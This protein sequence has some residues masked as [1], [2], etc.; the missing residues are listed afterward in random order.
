[1]EDNSQYMMWNW[2]VIIAPSKDQH[3]RQGISTIE[4]DSTEWSCRVLIK[5]CGRI[6]FMKFSSIP[7]Q[8]HCCCGLINIQLLEDSHN[9]SMVEEWSTN[10]YWN[11]HPISDQRSWKNPQEID[12]SESCE[13]WFVE[14]DL[15]SPIYKKL[16]GTSV[17]RNPKCG[18]NQ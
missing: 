18:S 11:P 10:L 6:F 8:F 7:V 12:V 15:W 2:K 14:R 16:G 3:D 1:M 9:R 5:L 17:I 13:K 4:T